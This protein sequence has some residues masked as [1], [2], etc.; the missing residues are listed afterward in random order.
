ETVELAVLAKVPELAKR[1]TCT[2]SSLISLNAELK[3]LLLPDSE[4][5]ALRTTVNSLPKAGEAPS[6]LLA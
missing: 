3:A 1:T 4:F 5:C 6:K 2:L